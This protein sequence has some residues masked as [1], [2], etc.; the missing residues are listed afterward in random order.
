MINKI[1]ESSNLCPTLKIEA[2][3]GDTDVYDALVR[4]REVRELCPWLDGM[5]KEIGD[6]S[7]KDADG[8]DYS[9]MVIAP[10]AERQMKERLKLTLLLAGWK[11]HEVEIRQ[12]E[13]KV[14][15][16]IPRKEFI[17]TVHYLNSGLMAWEGR[18]HKINTRRECRVC[19]REWGIFHHLEGHE[20]FAETHGA[21]CPLGNGE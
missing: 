13:E 15:A 5:G 20:E 11:L 1:W 18:E 7:M 4:C 14:R 9:E 8:G 10:E 17:N 6:L 12:T 21:G 19:A 3:P 16:S 2:G